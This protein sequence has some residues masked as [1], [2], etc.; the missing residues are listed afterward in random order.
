MPYGTGYS[1]YPPRKRWGKRST[2]PHAAS[3]TPKKK[4][5]PLVAKI[6]Y[7]YKTHGI[8]TKANAQKP[9]FIRAY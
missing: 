2:I 9:A 8:N 5:R 7:I 1:A 4:F 3:V 6:K